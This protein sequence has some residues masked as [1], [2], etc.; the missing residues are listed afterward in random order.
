MVVI[1]ATEIRAGEHPM[2]RLLVTPPQGVAAPFTVSLNA[3]Q[4]LSAMT[5][6]W[7]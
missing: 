2:V 4:S 3:G 6:G 7:G 5:K 1:T